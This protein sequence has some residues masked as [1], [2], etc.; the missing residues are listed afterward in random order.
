MT[1][2]P[3]PTVELTEDIGELPEEATPPHIVC[4][5]REK[6]LCMAPWHPEAAA[7]KGTPNEECC[8]KCIDVTTWM[9]CRGHSH[10]PFEVNTLG[11]CPK[12]R[13]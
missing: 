1:L 8:E 7:P 13:P 2:T 6:F 11:R 12:E 9:R 3:S 5:R 10:C 4:C